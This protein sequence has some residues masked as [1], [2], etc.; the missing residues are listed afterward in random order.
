MRVARRFLVSGMV[1]GVGY[2]YFAIRAA[3]RHGLVGYARN[4]DDGRVE[5]LAEGEAD[6]VEAFR[7]DLEKGP[8]FA[9][10][11]RVDV[12]ILEP[13]GRYTHFGVAY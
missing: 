7:R 5:V 12:E 11:T 6:A 13:S 2:R 10:V 8:T 4:L 1:Q 3:E 9:R